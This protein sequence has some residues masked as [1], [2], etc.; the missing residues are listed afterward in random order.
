MEKI[1]SGLTLVIILV[2]NSVYGARTKQDL[3]DKKNRKYFNVVLKSFYRDSL[4]QVKHRRN[5]ISAS[6][7][8]HVVLEKLNIKKCSK[9]RAAYVLL[10]R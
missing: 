1:L 2:G 5:N 3:V 9:K 8:S 6:T 4:I 10:L 7:P